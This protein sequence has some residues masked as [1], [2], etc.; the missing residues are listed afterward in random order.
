MPRRS[1]W[2]EGPFCESRPLV[3]IDS[4]QALLPYVRIYG[5]TG[6]V[7]NGPGTART[8]QSFQ[9]SRAATCVGGTMRNVLTAPTM[10]L[11]IGAL[12]LVPPFHVEGP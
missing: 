4:S 5:A 9:D 3:E 1:F 10:T 11:D 7:P 12:R 8:L 6:Y 2:Y